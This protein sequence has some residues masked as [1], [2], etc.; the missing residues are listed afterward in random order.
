MGKS[1]A[2]IRLSKSELC[3]TK[4]KEK[5]KIQTTYEITGNQALY[6]DISYTIHS[7]K[8]PTREKEMGIRG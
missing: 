3:M 7:M 1:A 8:L 4:E 6:T 2:N 5:E